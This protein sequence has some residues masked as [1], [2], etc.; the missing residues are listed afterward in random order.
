MNSEQKFKQ[1][2]Y[3]MVTEISDDF[4]IDCP[5]IV[6]DYR[7][8]AFRSYYF[9]AKNEIVFSVSA[10]FHYYANGYEEYVSLQKYF[11]GRPI[12]EKAIITV[13]LHEIA[14]AIVC[15]YF[16]RDEA[17]PHGDIFA[18]YLQEI[19]EIYFD[20]FYLRLKKFFL[21]SPKFEGKFARMFADYLSMKN[22]L[23]FRDTL[24]G[25]LSRPRKCPT[26]A[27]GILIPYEEK[28]NA[29]LFE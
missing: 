7:E 4:G 9:P 27:L 14:H 28:L 12:A 20:L 5:E 25:K 11:P 26:I 22:L 18:W 13:V 10:I 29:W 6:L 3:N 16:S 23:F 1:E 24:T 19:R 8:K 15:N 21:G 17:T 2:I